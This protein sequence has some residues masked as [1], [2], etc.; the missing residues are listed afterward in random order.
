MVST[1]QLKAEIRVQAWLR[2]CAVNGLMA[3]VARKGDRESGALFLKINGFARGCIVYSG[4]STPSG[5]ESWYKATGP[6]PVAEKDADAY[7]S[8][9]AT[10]DADLWVVEIEDPKGL[11]KMDAPAVGV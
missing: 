6:D 4:I 1:E 11:F 10:Y 8:R 7:L 5:Q 2:R 9:Q 3:T